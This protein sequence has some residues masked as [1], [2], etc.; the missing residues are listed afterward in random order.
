MNEK[1][2]VLTIVSLLMSAMGSLVNHLV[3]MR[4]QSREFMVLSGVRSPV[5]REGRD[6]EILLDIGILVV[7]RER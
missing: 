5:Y 4:P 7:F 6:I 2:I 1:S 3:F